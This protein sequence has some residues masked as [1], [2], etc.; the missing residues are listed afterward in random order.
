[1]D[2]RRTARLVGWSVAGLYFLCIA[3]AYAGAV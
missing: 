2:G 3:L 1:M